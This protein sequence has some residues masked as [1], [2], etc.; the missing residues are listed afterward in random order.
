MFGIKTKFMTMFL[1]LQ[2]WLI[3]THLVR[4][5]GRV[6][7]E[8]EVQ[9]QLRHEISFFTGTSL[10][11]LKESSVI[12]A[13]VSVINPDCHQ[14]TSIVTAHAVVSIACC[15][16]VR[17]CHNGSYDPD[18]PSHKASVT[19]KLGHGSPR[20][21]SSVAFTHAEADKRSGYASVHKSSTIFTAWQ[22]I[23][24]SPRA[25]RT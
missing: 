22:L 4:K 11:G 14:L 18:S 2:F 8:L 12:I 10:Y 5:T 20:L 24:A 17:P 1:R 23:S 21:L 6:G 9:V 19:S 3:N 16:G 7:R 15:V 13:T 25:A